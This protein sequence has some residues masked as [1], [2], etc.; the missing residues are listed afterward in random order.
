MYSVAESPRLM[1]KSNGKC[2]NRG[3]LD[4]CNGS[5]WSIRSAMRF[6]GVDIM[7]Y[8]QLEWSSSGVEA[9]SG[10]LDEPGPT[11]Q[12]MLSANVSFQGRNVQ[13]RNDIPHRGFGVNKQ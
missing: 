6:C 11:R 1:V 4:V 13:W 10:P 8:S 5:A 3:I 7:I 12:R 9:R 2:R